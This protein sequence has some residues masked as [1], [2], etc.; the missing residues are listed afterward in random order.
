MERWEPN[1]R[2]G[3]AT[4]SEE[5]ERHESDHEL[6]NIHFK[7]GKKGRKEGRIPS[8][9]LIPW[10]VLDVLPRPPS[11][12]RCPAITSRADYL[13]C[14]HILLP[15]LQVGR[16]AASGRP[17][18]LKRTEQ[19]WVLIGSKMNPAS[20]PPSS[21]TRG[22]DDA[23]S[24]GGWSLASS[25]VRG[26][27]DGK[28]SGGQRWDADDWSHLVEALETKINATKTSM[29][30]LLAGHYP[31]YLGTFTCA[32][33]VGAQLTKL[34][35]ETN[36]AL[37][38]AAGADS[39]DGVAAVYESER[40]RLLAQLRRLER[41]V[42]VLET[43]QGVQVSLGQV[44]TL[45]DRGELDGAA[46]EC[47]KVEQGVDGLFRGA[48]L[49]DFV[50]SKVYRAVRMQLV[51]KKAKLKAAA[52]HAL[53]GALSIEKDCIRVRGELQQALRALDSLGVLKGAL[54]GLSGRLWKNVVSRAAQ[55]NGVEVAVGTP[56]QGEGMELRL[57]SQKELAPGVGLRD[58]TGA[59][60]TVLQVLEFVFKDVLGGNV[61]WMGQLQCVW[62]V[63]GAGAL[64]RGQLHLNKGEAKQKAKA[65]DSLSEAMVC[66]L[67]AALPED[68][69]GLPMYH[70]LAERAKSTE[71]A[72][73]DMG[74]VQTSAKTVG[75]FLEDVESH[76]A[77]KRRASMLFAA[78]QLVLDDYFSI[79]SSA[80][81]TEPSF[82]LAALQ[83]GGNDLFKLEETRVTRCA[84]SIVELAIRAMDEASSQSSG[85]LGYVLYQTS[86][87]IVELFRAL[88]G[89]VYERELASRDSARVAILFHND[90]LFIAHHLIF[91]GH[92]FGKKAHPA[93]AR[94][95]VTV[96]MVPG[97]RETA[98]SHLNKQ[99]AAQLERVG[100][101]SFSSPGSDE[102]WLEDLSNRT[103][104]CSKEF[105]R[106]AE[107][108]SHLLPK[109]TFGQ[110]IVALGDGLLGRCLDFLVSLSS[111]DRPAPSPSEILALRETLQAL[112]DAVTKPLAGDKA[113]T[114]LLALTQVCSVLEQQYI[115]LH[116][117]KD[118][119][120]Q[121][122]LSALAGGKVR[123]L[124]AL[125]FPGE[126]Y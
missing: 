42:G 44:D 119:V 46:E 7:N 63:G 108:W 22:D 45:V 118:L 116:M 109:A 104:L 25:V 96:D 49:G 54:G 122:R 56:A 105:G 101:A 76:L 70:N 75:P 115:S 74:L 64:E 50:E 5:G 103:V 6:I 110:V 2:Q 95:I 92:V 113:A 62:G 124:A 58:G 126:K 57:V 10:W 87:D 51:R 29:Q 23:V 79:V 3:D 18:S 52:E 27:G 84:R 125:L 72:L 31:D 65:A 32:R 11:S 53:D 68:M 85:D 34:R 38:S 102:D 59:F 8:E 4:T 123:D 39:L 28:S 111:T 78:R 117:F 12:L 100:D 35:G 47:R 90:C 121:D 81:P 19:R 82:G 120:A 36:A 15:R 112:V 114:N 33:Q 40:N 106:L 1:W 43:L 14:S 37:Q 80:E 26:V 17:D 67:V 93:L 9:C 21:P 60:E 20:S 71:E 30:D 16:R 91:M 88:V 97:F 94:K 98:T 89:L 69:E 66:M 24:R 61:N 55:D 48:G 41:L 86:R 73:V 77:R 99:V 13:V 107:E 83:A